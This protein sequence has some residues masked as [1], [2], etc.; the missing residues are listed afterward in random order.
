MISDRKRVV[1]VRLR[2]RRIKDSGKLET[3]MTEL[4]DKHQITR[5]D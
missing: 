2:A 4:M 1:D 3:S 5:D